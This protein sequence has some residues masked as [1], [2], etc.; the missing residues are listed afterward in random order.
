MAWQS[1]LLY[2]VCVQGFTNHVSHDLAERWL[3]NFLRRSVLCSYHTH[4][5]NIEFLELESCERTKHGDRIID[6]HG[7]T[8][9]RR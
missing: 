5:D 7:Y 2:S 4:I 9:D 6:D 1:L 3:Q 8:G